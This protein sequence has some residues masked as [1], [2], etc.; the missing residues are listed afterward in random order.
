MRGLGLTY[1]CENA[2]AVPGYPENVVTCARSCGVIVSRSPNNVSFVA[3][4]G[5]MWFA[6]NV[7]AS[8]A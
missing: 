1:A 5:A 2:S 3:T 6:N 8:A 7:M 4:N